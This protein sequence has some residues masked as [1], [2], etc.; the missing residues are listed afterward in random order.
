ML[1]TT[2]GD[3]FEWQIALPAGTWSGLIGAAHIRTKDRGT[4]VHQ[5][6]G[7][8]TVAGDTTALVVFTAGKAVTRLWAPG[9]YR[10]DAELERPGVWGPFTITPAEDSDALTVTPDTTITTA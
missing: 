5:M 3:Y 8:V 2:R 10:I 4:I 6:T 7:T 1:T 9:E